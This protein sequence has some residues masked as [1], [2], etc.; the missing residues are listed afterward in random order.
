MGFPLLWILYNFY[1]RCMW[2][3]GMTLEYSLDQT[4]I[5]KCLFKQ[6]HDGAHN[7]KTTFILSFLGITTQMYEGIHSTIT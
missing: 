3:E 2:Y 1:F 7:C 4:T 5:M 6:C